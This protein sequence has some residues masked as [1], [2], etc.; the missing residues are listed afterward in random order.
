MEAPKVRGCRRGFVAGVAGADHDDIVRLNH[1]GKGREERVSAD[2]PRGT[3][4]SVVLGR[5]QAAG[6]G[7]VLSLSPAKC[8][9]P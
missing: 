3:C 8:R 7:F 9:T 5:A 6:V 1:E 4:Q 2:V